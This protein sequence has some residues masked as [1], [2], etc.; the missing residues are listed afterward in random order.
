MA[1]FESKEN[2]ALIFGGEGDNTIHS[3]GDNSLL[4][5]GNDNNIII[6]EGGN[7]TL[8]GGTGKN[9]FT[10]GEDGNIFVHNDG[11]ADLI[12]NYNQ[13]EDIIILASGSVKESVK[14][15]D[16]VIL[17]IADENK[18][19]GKITIQGGAEKI[20]TIYDE[21]FV[22]QSKEAFLD[23]SDAYITAA[24][25]TFEEDEDVQSILN[26]GADSEVLSEIKAVDSELAAKIAESLKLSY[27]VGK[28]YLASQTENSLVVE[29]ADAA[30]GMEAYQNTM[31]ALDFEA[32]TLVELAN[33]GKV[34]AAGEVFG[35]ALSKVAQ[36]LSV[37]MSITS[38]AAYSYM[39]YN[40]NLIPA[41]ENIGDSGGTL[42]EKIAKIRSQN[43]EIFDGWVK[44]NVDVVFA[45][46]GAAAVGIM[47]AA[48]VVG[49][50]VIITAAACYATPVAINW[51]YDNVLAKKFNEASGIPNKLK[52]KLK[53]TDNLNSF[54]YKRNDLYNDKDNVV[55]SGTAIKDAMYN[56]GSNV[57]INC[58]GGNDAVSNYYGVKNVL[59]YGGAGNDAL[60]GSTVYGGTGDDTLMGEIVYG[61][62]GDDFIYGMIAYG[63]SGDDYF[64]VSQ[65]NS[66][67]YGG[68]GNDTFSNTSNNEVLI[69]GGAGDDY[70]WNDGGK[71]LTID[72]GAGNDIIENHNENISILGGEGNDSIVSEGLY[73]DNVTI[74]AGGGNNTIFGGDTIKA[75]SGNDYIIS[76]ANSLIDAG[77]GNNTISGDV[78]GDK[79]Q[80]GTVKS[81]SG[82][83]LISYFASIE[84]GAGKDTIFVGG[85][86]TV[87]GGKGNDIFICNGGNNTI[88]D[89]T[90]SDKILSTL[91]YGGYHVEGSDL[92]FD[93]D[94]ED[95]LTI[96]K[97]AGKAI[98]FNSGVNFYTEEGVFDKNKKTVLLQSSTGN[99]NAKKISSLASIDGSQTGSASITGNNKANLI[100]TG[101]SSTVAGGKGNDTIFASSGSDVFVYDKGDGKDI[102]YNFGESDAINLG[103]NANIKDFKI[104]KDN[105]TF[106]IGSGSITVNNL[107][108]GINFNDTIFSNGIFIS[109]EGAKVLSSFS[110]TINLEE[111]WVSKADAS[112]AKKKVSINGTG[113]A[114]S[115]V[116]GNGKDTLLG[117]GGEDTLY[118]GKG[119]DILFGGNENDSLWGGKGNDTLTG[120]E[121]YDTFVFRAGEGTDVITDFSE[122]DM[123]KILDKKNAAVDFKKATFKNDTL[124]LSVNGGGK[125]ILK[126]ISE[127]TSININGTD[128]IVRNMI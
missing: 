45:V 125:I 25:K 86:S 40:E 73:A 30:E 29:P 63:E 94:Y 58:G 34:G 10:G 101:L 69:I 111:F 8:I 31:S 105:V 41:W 22:T 65:S 104:K 20:L 122:D 91:S 96:K 54:Y 78:Y 115:L 14:S 83:D 19:L 106:K 13:A 28:N 102:I 118:G 64:S 90:P 33:I 43:S 32:T 116:G 2:C 72:A 37:G 48:G 56:S 100:V 35:K 44:S 128:H 62:E 84:A 68:T 95:S 123:L 12:T 53:T 6:S 42:F 74:D 16:D 52:K 79:V 27:E 1:I 121:G 36:P 114:D 49:V 75:G 50:P 51:F 70:V 103:S 113:W 46:G 61:G 77:N 57:I 81:G 59:V 21:E 92:I 110:G 67:L 9:T 82:N 24:V 7:S 18:S 124:T 97:G 11:A 66:T 71:S 23:I 47:G 120:G 112:L 89:Y 88:T 38:Y 76:G 26:D 55:F 80:T 99:F 109:D 60:S 117:E 93:L 85:G 87:T 5:G 108:S 98:N 119:N 17:T 15:S 4:V 107:T 127:A 126:N 39:L 3:S